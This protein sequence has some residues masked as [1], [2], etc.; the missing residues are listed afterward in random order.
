MKLF[1]SC[2]MSF[3]ISLYYHHV[4][5]KQC[6]IQVRV[7]PFEIDNHVKTTMCG[8]GYSTP[9]PFLYPICLLLCISHILDD[10]ACVNR[11]KER[12]PTQ[13]T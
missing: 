8:N 3:F 4:I 13:V 12:Q 10:V 1:Y 2:L 9:C 7:F 6:P 11:S 5:N